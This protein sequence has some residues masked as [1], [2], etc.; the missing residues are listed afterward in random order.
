MKTISEN[1]ALKA[2][3]T[4]CITTPEPMEF[5][6]MFREV[7]L[8]Y[9][10][11]KQHLFAYAPG[12]EEPLQRMKDIRWLLKPRMDSCYEA[13]FHNC[14]TLFISFFTK[15]K[16]DVYMDVTECEADECVCDIPE[17]L[18]DVVAALEDEL[19]FLAN[20]SDELANAAAKDGIIAASEIAALKE[21]VEQL[22]AEV[23][24]A[25]SK[26]SVANVIV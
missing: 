18:T 24:A 15:A 16:D 23:K 8:G 14:A 21:K 11:T 25:E 26:A 9:E 20:E 2:Y 17:D 3:A 4:Y 6:E 5:G 10:V 22:E 12:H 7:P 1:K 13:G 19:V